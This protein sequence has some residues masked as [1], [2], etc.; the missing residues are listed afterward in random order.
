MYRDGIVHLDLKSNNIMMDDDGRFIVVDFGNT[1][2]LSNEVE[3]F[4][5]CL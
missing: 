3:S 4:D 2:Y 1:R 5:T